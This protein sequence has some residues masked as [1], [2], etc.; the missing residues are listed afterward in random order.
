LDRARRG[1]VGTIR[2]AKA[3]GEALRQAAAGF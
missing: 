2:Y 3:L 1:L